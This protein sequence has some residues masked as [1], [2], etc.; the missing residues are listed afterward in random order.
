MAR[1]KRGFTLIELL[2]VL[3]I[4]AILVLV[5]FIYLNPD[6]LFA[7]TRNAQRWSDITAILH[8]V[9][10]YQVDN[11]GNLPPDFPDILTT[12]GDGTNGTYNL[13]EYLVP[14]NLPIMPY[15]PQRGSEKSTCFAIEYIS[16]IITVKADCAELT[17]EMGQIELKW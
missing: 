5:V 9:K 16:G 10:T 15:D 1:R 6:K 17:N 8:G 2:I 4:I 12:I 3:T 13:G 7:K 11:K 14:Q